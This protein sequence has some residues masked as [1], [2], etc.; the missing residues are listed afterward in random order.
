MSGPSEWVSSVD[1][2]DAYSTGILSKDIPTELS[3]LH[4]LERL[5]DP[6]VREVL[7]ALPLPA[8][9]HCLD[10]GAGAGSIAYWLAG[11]RPA[12]RVTAADLDPRFLDPD[13]AGN[14]D[15][16]RVDLTRTEFPPAAFDL[17][18]TRALLAHL[19]GRDEL[20]HRSVRW[21]RP[22]GHLVVGELYLLPLEQTDPVLR[23]GL[24]VLQELFTAQ[25]TDVHWARRIPAV[26]KSGGLRDIQVRLTPLTLGLGQPADEFWQ[27]SLRQYLPI[28]RERG[29]R[30]A[31]ELAQL[32]RMLE[33]REATDLCWFFVTAW[34]R[35]PLS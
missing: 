33:D 28:L 12:G 23:P 11:H 6:P 35:R 3:R 10:M 30:T 2:T 21:L 31:D 15:V 9:A 20:L 25:G 5:L 18:H 24:A 4:A 22:G 29:L 16:A 32:E 27:R 8:E 1:L 7:A 14:L 17:V 26:L 34:G 13:R 19:P